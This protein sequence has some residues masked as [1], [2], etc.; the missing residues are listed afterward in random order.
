MLFSSFLESLAETVDLLLRIRGGDT[1]FPANVKTQLQQET[2]VS[3]SWG[4]EAA[5]G[6]QASP[7][8]QGSACVLVKRLKLKNGSGPIG[9]GAGWS[10]QAG[11]H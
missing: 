9:N 1:N 11:Q 6:A 7:R 2:R 8:E 3:P 5:G 10:E 4:T